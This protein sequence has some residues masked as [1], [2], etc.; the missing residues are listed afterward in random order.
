MPCIFNGSIFEN[1]MPTKS[2]IEVFHRKVAKFNLIILTWKK[3]Y[4]LKII[5]E[6]SSQKAYS[7]KDEHHG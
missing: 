4:Y 6:M 3:S 1:E 5:E 7:T 2:N